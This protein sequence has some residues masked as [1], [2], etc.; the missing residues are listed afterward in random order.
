MGEA[1]CHGASR[2]A[3]STSLGNIG[4]VGLRDRLGGEALWA[5][6]ADPTPRRMPVGMSVGPTLLG[7]ITRWVGEMGPKWFARILAEIGL[8][9]L[10]VGRKTVQPA[11]FDAKRCNRHEVTPQSR[12]QASNRAGGTQSSSK[13]EP[14]EK[15]CGR[16]LVDH[17]ASFAD[18][19][20]WPPRHT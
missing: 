7:T 10:G 2:D 15:G 3:A 13:A 5:M 14:S 19:P 20:S 17:R 18:P 16:G 8:P 1:I 12:I 9:P 4:P 6:L 11:R